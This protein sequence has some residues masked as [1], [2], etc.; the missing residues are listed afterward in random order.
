MPVIN[1]PNRSD[2][3]IKN[4]IG[5]LDKSERASK[6]EMQAASKGRGKQNPMDHPD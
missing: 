6:K 5:N 3:E 4:M 2:Q 1:T